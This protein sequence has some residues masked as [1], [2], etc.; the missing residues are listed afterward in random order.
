MG[1]STQVAPDTFTAAGVNVV[2]D[3]ELPLAYLN[4]LRSI[5]ERNCTFELDEFELV[6]LSGKLRSGFVRADNS[7]N[8]SL[9]ALD[10]GVHLLF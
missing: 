10:D 2:V 8:E 7:T 9:A 5:T 4:A 1:A 3:G 6:G